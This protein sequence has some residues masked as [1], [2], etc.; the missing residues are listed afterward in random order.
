[1]K[2]EKKVKNQESTVVNNVSNR[3]IHDSVENLVFLSNFLF[4]GPQFIQ[5]TY[6]TQ[7]FA[8]HESGK[9]LILMN[10]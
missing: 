5:H 4:L 7:H 1:M 3:E 6:A 2:V 10:L 9:T 8:M